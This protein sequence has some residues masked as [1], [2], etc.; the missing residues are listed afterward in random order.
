MN[1]TML[2]EIADKRAL[3]ELIY[4]QA[5]AV[6]RRDWTVYRT[7]FDDDIDFDLT[8]HT[9]RVIGKGF[10]LV[11]KG[12]QWVAQV[13][14]AVS[15]FDATQ[16]VISNACHTVDGDSAETVCYVLAH[17][18]LNNDCGDRCIAMGG[19]NTFGSVRKPNGWKIKTWHVRPLWYSGNPSLYHLAAQKCLT[20]IESLNYEG[21]RNASK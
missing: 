4:R 20:S 13:I 3:D 9:D 5:I 17:H 7:F 16:H 19:V 1:S 14:Q 10:G 11:T 2:Q 18:F 12:D 15:G 8:E 6:D 21:N